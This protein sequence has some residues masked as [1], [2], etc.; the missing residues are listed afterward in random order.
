MIVVLGHDPFAKHD[1][2]Q[3]LWLSIC[4][5]SSE[6]APPSVDLA[7]EKA[8]GLLVRDLVRAGKVNAAHDI[9]DGGMLVALAEMALA[10]GTGFELETSFLDEVVGFD[11]ATLTDQLFAETQGRVIVVAA[12]ER[13]I[14]EAAE[15]RGLNYWVVGAASVNDDGDIVIDP[16]A[17]GTSKAKVSLADLRAAHESFFREWMEG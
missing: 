9:S 4:R 17:D 5:G 15:Q 6:G 10:G 13:P 11:N 12:D 2:G 16:R 8:V 7:V 1:L 14:C 3:S